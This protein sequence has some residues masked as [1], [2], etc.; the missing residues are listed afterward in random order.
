MEGLPLSHAALDECAGVPR[1]M[2][3]IEAAVKAVNSLIVS[4]RGAFPITL[5][6]LEIEARMWSMLE[7][8]MPAARIDSFHMEVAVDH[9]HGNTINLD[10]YILY[11]L[12]ANRFSMLYDV[13]LRIHNDHVVFRIN[14]KCAVKKAVAR[15]VAVEAHEVRAMCGTVEK[16]KDWH[17]EC[18]ARLFSLPESRRAIVNR[19]EDRDMIPQNSE[20][21]S[22]GADSDADTET[23]IEIDVETEL[24]NNGKVSAK[25]IS[26][27]RS[28]DDVSSGS[29][30]M[31]RG[32]DADDDDADKNAGDAPVAPTLL[33]L[34]E[35]PFAQA[36]IEP[37]ANAPFG[38]PT[39]RPPSLLA[40]EQS[41]TLS[42]RPMPAPVPAPTS[43]PAPAA[44]PAPPRPTIA[45][46]SVRVPE[47]ASQIAQANEAKSTQKP[48]P[49]YDASTDY[50]RRMGE[51][52]PAGT[53]FLP[54]D[55]PISSATV[56]SSTPVPPLP[57]P[58]ELRA[59][60]PPIVKATDLGRKRSS[61]ASANASDN[62]SASDDAGSAASPNGSASKK[63]KR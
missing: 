40:E 6:N 29:A 5:T 48:Q 45:P 34:W 21:E 63:S 41:S 59:M 52:R 51:G 58:E 10:D 53:L 13:M 18:A 23:E 43:S 22:D 25:P 61:S 49:L 33:P 56:V 1:P 14:G 26:S 8:R 62:S 39:R 30:A 19:F 60:V 16:S 47:P 46:F 24:R 27:D 32:G 12:L 31:E 2:S 44:I 11:A 15:L 17:V 35:T 7:T 36:R 37:S 28:N 55:R 20:S 57:T 42:L 9:L 54:R 3:R 50:T 4:N 38:A